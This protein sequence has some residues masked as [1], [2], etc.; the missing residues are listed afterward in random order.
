MMLSGFDD[1]RLDWTDEFFKVARPVCPLLVRLQPRPSNEDL[2]IEFAFQN[3]SRFGLNYS[4]T[5][6]EMV[7][8]HDNKILAHLP[9]HSNAS[10]PA[11]PIPL[12]YESQKR[13]PFASGKA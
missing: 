4:G 9:R 13:L 3:K 6:R 8:R 11:L 1:P 5:S 2:L 10:M 12:D 7:L